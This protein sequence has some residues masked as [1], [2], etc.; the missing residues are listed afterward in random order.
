MGH[1]WTQVTSCEGQGWNVVLSL[2]P[3]T[4]KVP[5]T[6]AFTGRG[7]T[8][9]HRNGSLGELHQSCSCESSIFSYPYAAPVL[10][11]WFCREKWYL[12]YKVWF[13]WCIFGTAKPSAKTFI[14]GSF[15]VTT[16]SDIPS[17]NTGNKKK[18][19]SRC[20][21][22]CEGKRQEQLKCML[23]QLAICS[24]ALEVVFLLV[25]SFQCTEFSTGIN[26]GD[27]ICQNVLAFPKEV[28]TAA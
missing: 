21:F 28:R 8:A 20:L 16:Q 9:S 15:A 1:T 12:P 24:E 26:I 6:V 7:N 3:W 4:D 11:A 22:L 17:R 14:L 27:S 10:L 18:V 2:Q 19:K 13:P 5:G 25:C 23:T